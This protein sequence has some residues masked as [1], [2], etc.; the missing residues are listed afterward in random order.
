MKSAQVRKETNVEGND[1]VTYNL[2]PLKKVHLYSSLDGFQPN[3]NITYIYIL[4]GITLLILFIA[5]VNY[6]NL[7]TAQYLQAGAAKSASR[8][9]LGAGPMELFLQSLGESALLAF[10]ALLFVPL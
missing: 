2:E 10:I 3:G 5:S 6:T 1:Y 8:K 9:V 4:G 7:A